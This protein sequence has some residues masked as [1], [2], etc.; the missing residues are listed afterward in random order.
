MLGGRSERFSVT[1]HRQNEHM[2]VTH[3]DDAIASLEKANAELQPELL[4]AAGARKMLELYARAKKLASFGETVIA[5]KVDDAALIARATGTSVGKAKQV[6]ETCKALQDAEIVAEAFAGGGISLEQASEIARAEKAVPG[7]ATELLSVANEGS[8]QVLRE[9]SRK[10][11]LEAE[12][13]RGLGERQREARAARHYTDDLGMKRIDLTLTPELGE[14]ICNKAEAEAGRLHRAAKAEGRAEP[15]QRHLA[16]AFAKML[17][18]SDVK[19]HC[20]RADVTFIVSHEVAR[21]GWTDVREGEVCR[22]PG[23]GPVAPQVVKEIAEDAFLSGVFYDGR[24]L[25]HFKTFGRH[26]RAEVRRALEL[27]EPP[28]FDG[29]KCSECGNRFR[30]Q[31]DHLEPHVAE[32]PTS[33]GNLDWKCYRCHKRK[34]EDDRKSGK[35]KPRAERPPPDP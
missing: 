33:T 34:T 20:L 1:P 22:I 8:F 18:G 29:I 32:G 24:D 19:G 7:S 10:V 14:A 27:G 17:A 15:F 4:D 30:N 6:V 3:V 2:Q 23:L 25:R 31:K 12:Q 26:A 28:E 13:R 9:K 5:R 35:L 21:R 16:D 11:V